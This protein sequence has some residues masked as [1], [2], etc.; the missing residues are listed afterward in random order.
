MNF[1]CTYCGDYFTIYS[2]IK[3][4]CC[5]PEINKML[6]ADYISIKKKQI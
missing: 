3:L 1:N 2:N 4:F 5:L 6:H